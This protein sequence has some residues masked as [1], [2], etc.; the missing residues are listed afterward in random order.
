MILS[1]NDGGLLAMTIR[2]RMAG[3]PSGAPLQKE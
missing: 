1:W 3:V 2:W